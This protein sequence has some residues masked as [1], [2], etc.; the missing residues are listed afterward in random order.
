MSLSVDFL[1]RKADS[2]ERVLWVIGQETDHD[3]ISFD[4]YRELAIETFELTL[5]TTGKLLRKAVKA[6]TGRPRAVDSWTYNDVLRHA[7]K[8]GLLDSY[9]VGRWMQYRHNR[10][11]EANDEGQGF[12]HETLGLL[13]TYLADVR[14]LA[15]RI[16]ACVMPDRELQGLQLSPRQ[17]AVLDALLAQHVPQADV[18]AYGSRVTGGAHEGSD[19]DL[20][21]RHP[22]DVTQDVDGVF[23]L[24]AALQSS[25]LPMLVDVHVWSRL[26]ASFH[27]NIEAGYWVV[28]GVVG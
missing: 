11:S 12:V 1:L 15:P 9:A 3:S 26:P 19:L 6:F 28:R 22:L 13:P 24:K 7:C 4:L 14:A 20:V 23:E 16:Q 5:E 21:L 10:D 17:L 25:D 8:H 18:W 2:L 27:R